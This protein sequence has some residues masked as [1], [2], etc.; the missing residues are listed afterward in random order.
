MGGMASVRQGLSIKTIITHLGLTGFGLF[1]SDEYDAAGCTGAIQG[2]GGGILQYGETL[3][4][5][6][7]DIVN[8]VLI[9]DGGQGLTIY[10][11]QRVVACIDG[12]AP[13]IWISMP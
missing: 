6:G 10:H 3:N 8:G 11:H 9:A 1:G 13:R 4:F 7:V 12:N 2:G 5:V